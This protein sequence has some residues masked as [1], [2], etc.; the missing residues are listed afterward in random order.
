MQKII[1]KVLRGETH[2]ATERFRNS[3]KQAAVIEQ[4]LKAL[5]YEGVL[6]DDSDIYT[7]EDLL[8]RG[9]YTLKVLK[10]ATGKSVSRPSCLGLPLPRVCHQ[11]R[12]HGSLRPL[13]GL[14]LLCNR[15]TN[16]RAALCIACGS[17]QR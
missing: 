4:K 3:L 12:L 2:I 13:V 8:G 7:G 6:K 5:G 17:R 9:V 11:T 16:K 15:I 10:A 1:V 14:Q